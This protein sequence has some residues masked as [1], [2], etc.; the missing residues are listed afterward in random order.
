MIA[1]LILSVVLVSGYALAIE[2][3]AEIRLWPNGAPGSEGE[4]AAEVFESA[5]NSKLP[6][7][8]T[9]VHYPSI[10]V[11]LA[12]KEKANGMAVVVAPGGGHSQLVIDKEGW[13]IAEWLNRN[14]IAAFVLKYRLARAAGSHYTVERDA[15]ADAARA[16]RTVRSRAAEWGVDPARIG[17]MGFSAGGEV[18]ALIETRFDAGNAGAG[19][20][21]ERASSRP[22]FGRGGAVVFA[23]LLATQCRRAQRGLYAVLAQQVPAALL[24]EMDALLEVPESSNRS[25]LFRLKD[26]PPEGK[27]DTIAVFLENYTW[28]KQI[29]TAEIRFRGCH[30]ALIRQF[31]WSVRRNDVWHLREYPDEKRHAL[32]ACFLVEALKTILDHAIEMNDQYLIGMCRRSE[33][34]FESDLIEAR[35]RARRGNE[36]VLAAMEILLD[37]SRPR[38]EALDRLFQEIPVEDLQQAVTDCRALRH[39][40]LFGYAEA[41]ESRL[42]HLNRYQPQFFE[43]PFEA[44]RGSE[45]MLVA[46]NVAQAS[47]PIPQ[48]RPPSAILGHLTTPSHCQN[49]M[50][51]KHE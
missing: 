9:V 26:Y 4:T 33:H 27:P 34:A 49:R 38:S 24:P 44:Q 43:L 40:E 14:G 41:L 50:I 19:D 46:L 22:D 3:G 25:H 5:A 48:T 2:R 1:K 6:K 21:V 47:P 39:V 37:S 18:T 42:S 29:G 31:A 35:K 16:V 51:H 12:A 10:Y 11:F 32:L 15:L 45:L 30:P 20:P 23:R 7:R 28:L 13:E 36:Q 17:F 8:F